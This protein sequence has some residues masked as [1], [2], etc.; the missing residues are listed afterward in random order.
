MPSP[1]PRELLTSQVLAPLLND[2][3][4]AWDESWLA[5]RVRQLPILDGADRRAA[6]EE[7]VKVDLRQ[8][9]KKSK[10]RKTLD[11]YLGEYPELGTMETASLG[12]ILAE[13]QARID[14]ADKVSWPELYPRF[15]KQLANL[16]NVVRDFDQNWDNDR[17][18]E[19]MKQLPRTGLFRQ[20]LLDELVKLDLRARWEQPQSEKM[21]LDAYLATY[22]ELGTA[23]TVSL[24]LVLTEIEVR[25]RAGN[26]VSSADLKR[27][28][29]QMAQLGRG[30]E[31]VCEKPST[32]DGTPVPES[33]TPPPQASITPPAPPSLPSASVTPPKGEA[34]TCAHNTI[35]PADSAADIELQS[36]VARTK[37]DM[38]RYQI[39]R[40]LGRGAMGVVYL[41]RDAQLGRQV[42]LK[43]PSFTEKDSPEMRRFLI[44]AQ[45]AATLD[46]PNICQVYDVGIN[47]GIPF[48]TMAFIDGVPLNKLINPN[49]PMAQ[50]RVVEIVAKLA[51]ALAEAHRRGIIHRDLKPSNIMMNRRGEP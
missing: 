32:P 14:A 28:P 3:D 29:K 19:R 9:W 44:E 16:Q 2:H 20:L 41:A 37:S 27:F 24:D 11:F 25:R 35:R 15:P 17:L 47:G 13:L 49:Q 39:L 38:D 6:L 26:P 5:T 43:I 18:K 42:A 40:E 8:R 7:L 1:K 45:S 4:N 30:V 31:K 51:R 23:E 33:A 50:R 46:H 36:E 21:T 10:T 22:P 34:E 48:M 12:L